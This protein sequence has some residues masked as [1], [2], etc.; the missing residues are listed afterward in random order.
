M[1]KLIS[2][3][4][5]S[6]IVVSAFTG[7]SS[8]PSSADGESG[9]QGEP[10]K[11][12]LWMPPFGTEDAL[13]KSFWEAQLADF[14]T[15]N[16]AELV[17]E[18]VPWGNYEEKYLTGITSGAGPD[19]GYMYLEMFSDF[20]NMGALEPLDEYLTEEDKDNYLYLDKGF[21]NGK[22]YTIP[23]IVG[24]ARILVSNMDLLNAV[25]ITETPKTWDDLVTYGK[26]ILD[27]T[28]DVI[29]FYQEWADPAIGALNNIYYPFL[30]QAGGEIFNEEG[31]KLALDT[32]EA[33]EAA[34]FLYDL[35]F[36]HKILPE[37]AM[38]VAGTDI[39]T[40]FK[41]G[42]VAMASMDAKTA[43][44]L[45]D[46][47]IN[48][49]FTPSLV[50][51]T[52]GTFVAAD[53]LIMTSNSKN[54]ELAAELIKYMTSSEVMTAYHTDIAAFPPITKDEVYSDNPKFKEMYETE[55]E[56]LRTL[57]AVAGSFKAYDALYK[58]LQLMMLG[59]LTPEEALQQSVEY[60]ET[61]LDN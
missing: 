54:K 10:S 50:H 60:S 25:G 59:E 3:M 61:V 42:K 41:E 35:K 31:T 21:I 58:N 22:Q 20:I 18:I 30:W 15:E 19:V 7:C 9:G 49:D 6:L 33:L 52:G 34:Q 57:P 51:K 16:N 38:S 56:Y 45:D 13:D 48:W 17:V 5:T 32:P 24:N 2:I 39:S 4:L 12:V 55:S 29:P 46:L 14:A 23:F 40:M 43:T 47:G 53:A 28:P 36:T 1:K 8:K 37:S 27:E 26:K 44:Q 11:L